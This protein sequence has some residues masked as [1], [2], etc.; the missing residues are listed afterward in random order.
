MAANFHCK[1]HKTIEKATQAKIHLP[2]NSSGSGWRISVGCG[3]DMQCRSSLDAGLYRMHCPIIPTQNYLRVKRKARET[4]QPYYLNIKHSNLIV[5]PGEALKTLTVPHG[6]VHFQ[7]FPDTFS[8][9][10]FWIHDNLNDQQVF[11]V[12]PHDRG[13]F[14]N[15]YAI[16]E[17]PT[18]KSLFQD[19]IENIVYNAME[20]MK[21]SNTC[22]SECRDSKTSIQQL[23]NPR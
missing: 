4:D 18:F 11:T 6:K 3:G 20:T 15:A 19:D 23:R 2:A 22:S 14:L 16:L 1:S 17:H 5:R 21:S 10:I 13:D 9:W 12:P 8:E 7:I